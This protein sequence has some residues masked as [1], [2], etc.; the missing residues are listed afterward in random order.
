MD[1]I[2]GLKSFHTCIEA[3]DALTSTSTSSGRGVDSSTGLV[4]CSVLVSPDG[5]LLIIPHQQQSTEGKS[6]S[7]DEDGE[8]K[9]TTGESDEQYGLESWCWANSI[10][11]NELGEE[12]KSAVFLGNDLRKHG[13]KEINGF[14]AKG[15]STP[16]TSLALKQ[17]ADSIGDLAHF[18]E[19]LVL[20]K[21]ANATKENQTADMIRKMVGVDQAEL[22]ESKVAS[23]QKYLREKFSAESYHDRQNHFRL[24]FQN[25][26]QSVVLEVSPDRVGPLNHS[27]GTIPASLKALENFYSKVAEFDSKRWSDLSRASG[28]LSEIQS[29]KTKMEERVDGRQAALQEAMRRIK[30]MEDYLRE[31][32]EDAKNKWDKVH[33]AEVKV[34]RLVEEKLL[35]RTRI[36]EEERRKQ[37]KEEE[38]NRAKNATGDSEATSSAILDLVSAATASMEEGSFEP[39]TDFSNATPQL[40]V[41]PII[42]APEE[43][44]FE[45]DARYE[46]EVQHRLPELRVMA[47]AA[48][49]AVEDAANTLLSVLSNLDRI[50]RS[51]HLAAETCLVS[52]GNAQASC[53][54]SVIAIERES[55]RER[56]R[57]LDE[58]ET[59]VDAIDVRA[60][61]NHYIDM[62]KAKPGGRSSLGEDDDGGVASALNHLRGDL[63]SEQSHREFGIGDE[64]MSDDDA[65]DDGD[66]DDDDEHSSITPEGIEQALDSLFGG[67]STDS[68]SLEPSVELLCRIARGQSQRSTTRRSTICYYMNA[69]RSTH[70]AIPSPAQFEGLCRVF[71]AVLAGCGTKK[72]GELSSAILLMGLSEHFYVSTGESDADKTFVRSRLV[73]HPLWEKDQFW[74]RAL[75]STILEKLNYSGI[76]S[77]FERDSDRVMTTENKERSEW[78]E[79]TKT[80]WHDL[81]RAERCQ[82]ASQVNAI[83]FAQVSTMSQSMM[84]LCTSLVKTSAF[85][86]RACV[87]NQLP[88][89]QRT[90][91]LR[92]LVENGES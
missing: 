79:A 52:C 80:R 82:A 69:K 90:A 65:K 44:E 86:R 6:E 33:R 91:L 9:D 43:M 42:K 14:S 32:K 18:L 29:A 71:A 4:D 73:G 13:D 11:S 23:Y 54:R 8:G 75:H 47:L 45:M 2:E 30:A 12:Y 17:S 66:D 28:A 76:M 70:S 88:V 41:P 31:C 57:L 21:K 59:V 72:D 58:L 53:L 87:R 16:A 37:M 15:W 10:Q 35:R 92:H 60:D 63:G 56:L 3:S 25:Q 74:D 24:M 81:T 83:V 85:V 5:E 84:E 77:N 22:T 51:A 38:A 26:E 68:L 1:N 61:L 7:C 34:T 40:E 78:T 48:N 62:D 67:G 46:F 27:G 55:I 20:A 64:K 50:N 89:S 49:E 36:Q 19:E 39:V